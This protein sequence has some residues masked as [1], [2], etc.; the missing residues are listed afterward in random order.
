MV[1]RNTKGMK[2]KWILLSLLILQTNLFSMSPIQKV[3]EELLAGNSYDPELKQSIEEWFSCQ[4]FKSFTYT[5]CNSDPLG[6]FYE[7]YIK[8]TETPNAKTIHQT[9]E[10]IAESIKY[11]RVKGRFSAVFDPHKKYITKIIIPQ[12]DYNQKYHLL[13]A[14]DLQN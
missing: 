5:R 4:S 10:R 13:Q 6:G 2:L 14:I 9:F 7:S 8:V 3:V 1:A 12:L 11:K